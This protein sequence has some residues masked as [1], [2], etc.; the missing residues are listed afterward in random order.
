MLS[1]EAANTNI[2]VF[3]LI[4]AGLDPMIYR[5]QGEHANQCRL[6]F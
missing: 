4:L 6:Q 3:G 1:R 2:I 5:T